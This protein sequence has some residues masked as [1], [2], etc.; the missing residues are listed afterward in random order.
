ML[1]QST[2][3]ARAEAYGL[4]ALNPQPAPPSRLERILDLIGVRAADDAP[5]KPRRAIAEK[6][7]PFLGDF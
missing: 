4:P 3:N 6:S 2:P 1:D 7:R 5:A